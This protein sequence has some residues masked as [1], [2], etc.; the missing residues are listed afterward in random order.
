MT[1]SENK[2]QIAINKIIMPYLTSLQALQAYYQY[3]RLDE[4]PN[5]C[6]S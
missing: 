2:Y 3:D 6:M 1:V 4:Q 5:T